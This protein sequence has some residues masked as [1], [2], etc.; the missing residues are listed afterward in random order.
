MKGLL[1]NAIGNTNAYKKNKGKKTYTV[2]I[3]SF[4][5]LFSSEGWKICE[6]CCVVRM[7]CD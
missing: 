6:P 7:I 5:L 4:C 1:A 2:S 3:S